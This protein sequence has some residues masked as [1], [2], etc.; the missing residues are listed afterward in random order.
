MECDFT[1][2]EQVSQSCAEFLFKD[3]HHMSNALEHDLRNGTTFHSRWSVLPPPLSSMT[4]H[5]EASQSPRSQS[6]AQSHTA[7]KPP[8]PPRLLIPTQTAVPS[9]LPTSMAA[10]P[11]MVPP[12]VVSRPTAVSPTL[13]S[14]S[15]QTTSSLVPTQTE[16]R[17]AER[18]VKEDLYYKTEFC[19]K[20]ICPYKRKCR[21]AHSEKEK[22]CKPSVGHVR[23]QTLLKAQSMAYERVMKSLKQ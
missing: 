22:N 20:A 16:L 3:V 6:L 11:S 4:W 10:S 18:M 19:N 13:P 12:H 5:F 1:Q 8:S 23:T 9:L 15:P 7:L 21:F 17:L 14:V 2:L